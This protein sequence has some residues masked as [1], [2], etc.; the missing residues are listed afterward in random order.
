V[1]LQRLR[2][3]NFAEITGRSRQEASKWWER[4][5]AKGSRPAP[6]RSMADGRAQL[7]A[8]GEGAARRFFAGAVDEGTPSLL[9][10]RAPEAARDLIAGAERLL[11]GRFDLLGY[12]GLSFGNAVDWHVDPVSGRR[13]PLVHWTRLNPLDHEAVGDSKVV[14]ELNRHQ[15]LVQLAQAYR[16]TGDDRYAEAFRAHAVD[17]LASNPVGQGINWASSLELSYRLIAWCWALVLFRGAPALDPDLFM[18]MRGSIEDQA[19][20]VAKYLSHY[21][22]PNTHLTGEA[23]GL[24]Y[25]GSLFPELDAAG[26]WREQ[27]SRILIAESTRQVFADGVYFEQSTC[28]QRYTVEIVLH[29]LILCARLGL[30]V[31]SAVSERAQAMLDFLLAVRLPGGE[32]PSIGD[33]DGGW[34]LPLTRRAADDPRGVFGVAA[35]LFGR[36]D[37][38]W[39][40]GDAAPEVLWMLGPAGLSA[41]EELRPA[42]P[43]G[44]PSRLF[45]DGG[46][47]VM[48]DSWGRL[49]NQ[50]I[51]DV[52]PLG[53]PLSAGH[54]H[55]DLLS[56]QCAAFGQPFLI[57]AGT[58]GYGQPTWRDAF[59]STAAHSTIA[60]DGLSQAVP[61]GP[62]AWQQRPRARLR[63]WISSDRFEL[64]D[65]DHDAYLRLSDPVRHRRQVLFVKPRYWVVMDELEG[66]ESHRA[67]LRFQFAPVDVTVGVDQWTQASSGGRGLALR[68]FAT[69]PLDVRV[70]RGSESPVE[71]W[72][73]A[74]YGQRVPAP[75]VIYAT[76][77]PLPLRIFTLLLPCEVAGTAPPV[78][79]PL[80]D[81]EGELVGLGFADGERVELDRPHGT[82]VHR[83]AVEA[84]RIATGP[85]RETPESK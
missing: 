54:G 12:S 30:R 58:G 14:W 34:L 59:R 80:L 22:S 48:R 68:P 15:W 18:R 5:S 32:V 6:S 52:G 23:L 3:M 33:A 70:V 71:G 78:V 51:F 76:D 81:A 9:M 84:S 36:S 16:M 39:A 28:Y 79:V 25:A 1:N 74:D 55:A 46:Y 65:A 50:L 29:F 83:H 10:D 72:V 26:L 49:A 69:V 4:V 77:A 8:F 38:A 35:A 82:M 44:A 20:H 37:Y 47:I 13:A 62:F 61:A 27:G 11:E 57:D 64:A 45:G 31:P 7:A 21:F 67:E 19:T 63:L 75:M 24:F 40:A 2:R 66:E 60:V 41:L 73:S 53:C 42:P 43:S 17:W 85:N 56:I